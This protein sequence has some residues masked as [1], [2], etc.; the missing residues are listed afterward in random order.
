MQFNPQHEIFKHAALFISIEV[1][2]N[3]SQFATTVC[4][5]KPE[6][7]I[8][9]I[10]RGLFDPE[11]E[12]AQEERDLLSYIADSLNDPNIWTWNSLTNA[13]MRAKIAHVDNDGG[14]VLIT[15]Y[16]VTDT[17]TVP[18]V[19]RENVDAIPGQ[20]LAMGVL[21][22]VATMNAAARKHDGVAFIGY[23][24]KKAML[25]I[26][27]FMT[28]ASDNYGYCQMVTSD[29]D[30]DEFS[31]E[32][33]DDNMTIA[34]EATF[35]SKMFEDFGQEILDTPEHV[36][37]ADQNGA[38]FVQF[39]G[40]KDVVFGHLQKGANALLAIRPIKPSHPSA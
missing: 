33:A 7:V 8:P 3:N 27:A 4:A 32:P 9:A 2:V 18:T 28:T 12:T 13:P 37:S 20:S 35:D 15:A 14:E 30:A 16:V 10:T 38:M 26:L 5:D 6:D 19:E 24:E 1:T 17:G 40:P 39:Y 22:T 36:V 25:D 29:T 23:V 11:Q 21:S 34:I 31:F